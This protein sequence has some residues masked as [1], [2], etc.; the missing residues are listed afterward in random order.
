VAKCFYVLV[1]TL[2]WSASKAGQGIFAIRSPVRGFLA[3]GNSAVPQRVAG[4]SRC[5]ALALHAPR[6]D[7]VVDKSH[8]VCRHWD[9]RDIT[10]ET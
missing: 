5:G 3:Q 2:P 9:R 6:H 8:V 10:Y 1:K 7:T 4:H